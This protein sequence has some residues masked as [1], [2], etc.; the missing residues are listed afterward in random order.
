MAGCGVACG[1]AAGTVTGNQKPETSKQ[2]AV[3]VSVSSFIKR[4]DNP[5]VEILCRLLVGGVFVYASIDKILYPAEF[6]KVVYNYQM[7]PVPLSNLVAMSLP[8]LEL[9]TGLALL[10]GVLRK[11]SSLVLSALLVFF[12]IALSVNI[13]RGVDIDCGCMS[14]SGGGRTIGIVTVLEDV[15]LLVATL[16]VLGRAVRDEGEQTVAGR[17]S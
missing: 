13:Y 16:L 6:A 3:L 4:L 17:S 10:M 5:W 11:E 8:W 1:V 12:I 14:L 15:I 9:F 2:K 7:L